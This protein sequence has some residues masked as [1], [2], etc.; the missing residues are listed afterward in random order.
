M[1]MQYS[2]MHLFVFAEPDNV[3]VGLNYC[4][5]RYIIFVNLQGCASFR[6]IKEFRKSYKMIEYLLQNMFVMF[7]MWG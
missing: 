4:D 3:Q 7:L 2:D 5:T 1:N 6:I